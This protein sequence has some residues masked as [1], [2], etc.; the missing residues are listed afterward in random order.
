MARDGE[1][2][3]LFELAAEVAG[4]SSETETSREEGDCCLPIIIPIPSARGQR[5]IRRS[6]RGVTFMSDQK[7]VVNRNKPEREN[8]SAI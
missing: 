2:L 8:L 6:P 5:P 1:P 7:N 4:A 3:R